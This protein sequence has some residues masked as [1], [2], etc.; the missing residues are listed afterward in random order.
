MKTVITIRK[1]S[2]NEWKVETHS[3]AEG[4]TIHDMYLEVG[5]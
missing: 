1:N 3:A 4:P 2:P 5:S